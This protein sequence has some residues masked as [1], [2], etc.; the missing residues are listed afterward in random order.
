MRITG[1]YNCSV[2]ED[3]TINLLKGEYMKKSIL[4]L[5]LGLLLVWHGAISCPRFQPE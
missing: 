3:F 5:L 1:T 4:V 2:P